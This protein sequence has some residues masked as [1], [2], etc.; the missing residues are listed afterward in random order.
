[1]LLLITLDGEFRVRRPIDAG[2]QGRD[3]MRDNKNKPHRNGIG[4][5]IANAVAD[6]PVYIREQRATVRRGQRILARIIARA[7]LR[8]QAERGSAPQP[9]PPPAGESWD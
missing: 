9:G 1:M 8:R 6:P 7:H 2:N 3:E 4:R 5:G